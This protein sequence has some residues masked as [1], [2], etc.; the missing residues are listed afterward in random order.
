MRKP[1]NELAYKIVLLNHVLTYYIPEPPPTED[2]RAR[3]E[4]GELIVREDLKRFRKEYSQPMAMRYRTT[5]YT[6]R[7][8]AW[9]PFNG[10]THL[11]CM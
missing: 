10:S 3:I 9:F 8:I 5:Y 2:D 6:R 11:P 4:R 1:S 7:Y